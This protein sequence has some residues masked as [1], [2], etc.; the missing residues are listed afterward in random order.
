MKKV[1]LPIAIFLFLITIPLV[2]HACVF[3]GIQYCLKTKVDGVFVPSFWSSSFEIKNARMN[4]KDKIRID[5]ADLVVRYSMVWF[6][7]NRALRIRVSSKDPSIELLGSWAKLQGVEKTRLEHFE[8]DLVLGKDGLKEIFL[9]DAYSPEF[10][11][12]IK[13]SEKNSHS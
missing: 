1:V 3:Q 9:V 12:Q 4:W 6:F 11:F 2:L 5:E 13:R 8:A 10:Q 7:K